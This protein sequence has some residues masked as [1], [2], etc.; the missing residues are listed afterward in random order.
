MRRSSW[1][2]S[3]VK[4]E[5]DTI[6]I[7]NKRL[8]TNTIKKSSLFQWLFF[9]Y[10]LNPAILILKAKSRVI[11][12]FNNNSTAIK[13]GDSAITKPSMIVVI[14]KRQPVTRRPI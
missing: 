3:F 5:C 9:K 8:H 10:F 14:T 2:I 6:V 13:V 1:L 7:I 12:I 4:L 11:V